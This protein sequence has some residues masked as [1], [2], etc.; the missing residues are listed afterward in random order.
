MQV[1]KLDG[2]QALMADARLVDSQFTLSDA[3]LAFLWARMHAID[4]VK[5]Y[6]RWVA[7]PAMAHVC[8]FAGVPA[9][10]GCHVPCVLFYTHVALKHMV[11]AY[12]S[13]DI[14]RPRP[15]PAASH[16]RACTATPTIP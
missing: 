1:L 14:T 4:E 5:D 6:Q 9:A 7:L 2:W 12:P 16:D 13:H 8:T 3:T 15:L 11:L 10:L